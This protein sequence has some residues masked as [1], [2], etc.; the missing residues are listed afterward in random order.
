MGVHF[1]KNVILPHQNMKHVF[2]EMVM[3]TLDCYDDG[4][5]DV[6]HVNTLSLL[7]A[8]LR[9]PSKT[10]IDFVLTKI[11]KWNL[12][13]SVD[14]NQ[15]DDRCDAEIDLFIN[16]LLNSSDDIKKKH[17]SEQIKFILEQ[18]VDSIKSMAA[19]QSDEFRYQ[20]YDESKKLP[21]LKVLQCIDL[22]GKEYLD[23][24]YLMKLKIYLLR[25]NE[26]YL[27]F[28]QAKEWEIIVVTRR[29][30]KALFGIDGERIIDKKYDQKDD[31]YVG[32]ILM[33]HLHRYRGGYRGRYR[34][35]G[36]GRYRRY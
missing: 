26:R 3:D 31:E 6:I 22:C 27:H 2:D 4:N 23:E 7:N 5:D 36:R 24:E 10:V 21:W 14:S 34:G 29:I 32:N 17:C 19:I 28:K 33:G 15:R 30:L 13:K 12:G 8:L 20:R 16:I 9:I 35:R 18:L 25:I 11:K 1:L